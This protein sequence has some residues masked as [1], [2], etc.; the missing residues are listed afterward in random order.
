ML[1]L[2]RLH[3]HQAP[4]GGTR[5]LRHVT[6]EDNKHLVEQQPLK[7]SQPSGT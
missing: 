7:D 5:S 4:T 3:H 2:R 1:H 6:L